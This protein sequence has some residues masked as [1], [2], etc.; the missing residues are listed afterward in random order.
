[1]KPRILILDEP[2]TGLDAATCSS[3]VHTLKR[4]VEEQNMAIVAT[5]H[6]PSSRVF[7]LFDWIYILR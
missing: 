3:L 2:T 5:I 6:Q 4:L 7:N 1:M